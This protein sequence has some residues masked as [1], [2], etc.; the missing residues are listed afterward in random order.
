MPPKLKIENCGEIV[1]QLGKIDNSELD[2]KPEYRLCWY[3][4]NFTLMLH[5]LLKL[6]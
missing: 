3:S 5:D 6:R 1:E 2:Y 4:V